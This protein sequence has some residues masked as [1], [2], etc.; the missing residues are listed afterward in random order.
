M[1]DSFPLWIGYEALFCAYCKRRVFIINC[2]FHVHYWCQITSI[3]LLSSSLLFVIFR[4]VHIIYI[5]FSLMDIIV[6]KF[7]LIFSHE[8]PR[9]HAQRPNGS[10]AIKE[11]SHGIDLEL[12]LHWVRTWFLKF[13]VGEHV[14]SYS[15]SPDLCHCHRSAGRLDLGSGLLWV[16]VVLHGLVCVWLA[17]FDCG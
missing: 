4:T 8:Y 9:L 15:G 1:I 10:L 2:Y 3:L 14:F 13:L 11:W 16:V 12:P 6:M 17:P 7:I 5:L